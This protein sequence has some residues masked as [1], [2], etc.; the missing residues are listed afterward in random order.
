MMKHQEYFP[1]LIFTHL[2]LGVFF[3][4]TKEVF[5]KPVPS[6]TCSNSQSAE[7]RKAMKGRGKS[8]QK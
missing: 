1:H 8:C 2:I 6:F 4:Y 5:E 7:N 3:L